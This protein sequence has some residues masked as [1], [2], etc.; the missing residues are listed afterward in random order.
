MVEIKDRLGSLRSNNGGERDELWS[1]FGQT[2][3]FGKKR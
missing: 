2:K 3:L 1:I